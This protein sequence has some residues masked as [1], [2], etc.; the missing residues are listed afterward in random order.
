MRTS[1]ITNHL[2]VATLALILYVILALSYFGTTGN[3]KQ[4]TQLLNLPAD[5]SITLTASD[6][7][8][9]ARVLH[10][11][12]ERRLSVLIDLRPDAGSGQQK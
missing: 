1:K 11:G 10:N 5:A 3:Y 12:D 7:F 2:P 4:D 6:T 9:P 8:E